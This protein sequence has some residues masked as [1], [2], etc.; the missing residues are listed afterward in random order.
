MVRNK[1]FL[2][3]VLLVILIVVWLVVGVMQVRK[4]R[5]VQGKVN[6]VTSFYPFMIYP[7]IGGDY[8]NV[9]NL[10]PAGVE[11]HDW[12]P[13]SRDIKNMPRPKFLCIKVQDLKVGS[14]F[15]RKSI[16]QTRL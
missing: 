3:I 7:Q 8:V 2:Y 15:S 4:L 11:P 14:G 13:K 9:I 6:V 1:K 10:V 5:L 12:S 16:K